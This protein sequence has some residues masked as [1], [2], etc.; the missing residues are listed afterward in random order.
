V[1]EEGRKPAAPELV[2]EGT[3]TPWWSFPLTTWAVVGAVLVWFAVQLGRFVGE[4]PDL[5]GM[6]GIRGSLTIWEEGFGGLFKNVGS[7]GIHPPLMDLVNFVA[8]GVLGKD[9]RSLHLIS[10]VLFALFAGGVE[11]F[12]VPFIQ[13]G[14]R[15]VLAAFTITI[16]PAL[17][18]TLFNV[19]REG[20]IMII[21]VIALAL[22]VRPLPRKPVALGLVLALLPLT[23]E[24]GIVFVAPFALYALALDAPNL[25]A[26]IVRAA[27]VAGLPL[28][29]ELL[30]RLVL[31]LNNASPWSTWVLSDHAD[32]GSYVVALRAMFGFESG[33][34]FRQNLAN[35]FIVN[36]L[37]LPAILALA[38]LV[39]VFRRP[40][41][42]LVRRAAVLLVGI[43]V[44]YAW[45]TL[46]FPTFTEPRYATPLIMLTVLLV[47]VGLGHWPRKA[48][49]WVLGALLFVFVAGAWA[50]TDPI[51]RKVFG[52]TSVGGEQ[53]YNTAERHRGPDRMDIN[54]QLLN[55]TKRGNARLRRIYASG[56]TLVTGDCNAMKFGE[57]LYSVGLHA[58]AYDRGLPGAR[59][60]KCVFPQ[61]LPPNAANG[62][63][64]IALVRTP[65]EDAAEAPLA[66]SGPSII[67][68]H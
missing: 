46:T 48:Q 25:R 33:E 61:D 22:A 41:P 26:R 63:E 4:A 57:K 56:A 49:P 24:N 11:R 60:L 19:W 37:W 30:W 6:I 12:L 15:R 35:A 44:I 36:W 28:A 45:T 65:E 67:V 16:C 55:A 62:P 50:P 58:D 68:I 40:S 34:Y 9:P 13:S 52:T 47:F 8:F 54:F 66:V 20:L 38:T 23:K 5:D 64:K 14:G 10:I 17:A 43:S 59:P 39:F 7:E 27:W 53:I 21:V 2:E 3:R 1:E 51:S 18:L 31:E 29:S 42:A 32:E